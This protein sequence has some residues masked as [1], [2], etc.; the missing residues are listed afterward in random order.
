MPRSSDK[1]ERL[2]ESAKDLIH[3]QGFNQT[4][5][6]DIARES[7]VPLGNVY[8]YFRTKDDIG[9]AVIADHEANVK[10]LTRHLEEDESDPRQR[11]L[12]FLNFTIEMKE[13]IANFGCPI[14]SLCQELDKERS[15][16]SE[17]AGAILKFELEWVITQFEQMGQAQAVVHGHHLVVA[18]CGTCV[19]AKALN[20]PMVVYNE[21]GHLKTWIE[22]MS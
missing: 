10:A 6:A 13:I 2:L 22:K 21:V 7:G 12:N 16:L 17:K 14:G 4:S 5:L 19:L 8:Y 18:L 1:K 11:I 3:K 15:T 20:D 9:S